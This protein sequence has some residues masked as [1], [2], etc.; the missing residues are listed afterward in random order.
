MPPAQPPL[1]LS[2]FPPSSLASCLALLPAEP[3]RQAEWGG[4]PEG[5]LDFA[6]RL[7]FSVLLPAW[8]ELPAPE[9]LAGLAADVALRLSLQAPG[10][11]GLEV[12]APLPL[13][14]EGAV[15][16][17]EL[18]AALAL[19]LRGGSHREADAVWYG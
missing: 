4:D 7:A 13:A 10:G 16:Q 2:S 15:A 3:P 14:G 17:T 8:Q 12:A 6:S 1:T 18:A 5:L 9:A 11:I 19:V